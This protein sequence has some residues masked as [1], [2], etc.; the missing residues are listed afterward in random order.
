MFHMTGNPAKEKKITQT[1]NISGKKD[2]TFM[3]GVWATGYAVANSDDNRKYGL[4]VEFVA[5][6]GSTVSS[7]SSFDARTLEWQFLNDVFIAKKDYTSVNV[8]LVFYYNC[9]I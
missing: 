2:D 7:I 9:T 5:S 8:S 4:E 6:D 3:A 1:V